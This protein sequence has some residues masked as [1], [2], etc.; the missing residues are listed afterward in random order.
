MSGRCRRGA[1][2][3]VHWSGGTPGPRCLGLKQHQRD[4]M[5]SLSLCAGQGAPRKRRQLTPDEQGGAVTTVSQRERMKRKAPRG[6]LKRVF[7]PQKPQLGLEKSGDFLVHLSCLLFVRRSAEESRTN[8]CE[9]KWRVTNKEHV[10]A[11][12]KVILKKSP[13]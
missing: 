4:R 13:G 3:R 1:P 9:K 11:A 8:A 6:S 12:A 2:P 10:L 7:K 5:G